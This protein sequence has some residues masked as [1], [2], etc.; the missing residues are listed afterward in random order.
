[1]ASFQ[2]KWCFIYLNRS[3]FLFFF[4]THSSLMNWCIASSA[5][6]WNMICI[7]THF[8]SLCLF[9]PA[10]PVSAN[11]LR[12]HISQSVCLVLLYNCWNSRWL[13]GWQRSASVH[14]F[15]CV[16][17]LWYYN[18]CGLIDKNNQHDTWKWVPNL[19]KSWKILKLYISSLWW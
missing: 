7:Q 17:V 16:V 15:A 6:L 13:P 10:G 1:M 19:Q 3:F 12:A 18:W 8:Q 5:N 11:T 2:L 9:F 14:L 4:S